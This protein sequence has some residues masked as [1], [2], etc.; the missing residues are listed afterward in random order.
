[1]FGRVQAACSCGPRASAHR[2]SSGSA[3]GP[4][5]RHARA[6]A[7]NSSA[8]P[9]CGARSSPRTRRVAHPLS[10]HLRSLRHHQRA[11]LGVGCQHAMEPDEVQSRPGHQRGQL[12]HELPSGLTLY[13]VVLAIFVAVFLAII[14]IVHSPYGQVLKAIRK[15]EPRAISLGYDV[16]RNRRPGRRAEDPGA[17]LRHPVRRALVAVGRSGIADPARRHGHLRRSS[18]RR[19]DHHRPARLPG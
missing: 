15:N 16:G 5:Q 8:P 3:P 17:R 18:G 19:G 13:C 14:C 11:Q 6:A 12:R 10:A 7:P 1:M 2:R 4:D 9:A